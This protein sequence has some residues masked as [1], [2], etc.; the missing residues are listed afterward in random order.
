MPG[1]DKN[2]RPEDNTQGFQVN[3]QNI[4]RA[5]QPKKFKG[6][7]AT[8]RELLN[9]DGTIVIENVYEL[10]E[11][12]NETGKK[13]KKAKV[14]I[15]RKDIIILAAL[16]KSVQGDMRAVE[17]V[18][19]RIEGKALQPFRLESEGPEINLEQL[20]VKE[21]QQWYKLLDKALV[22]NDI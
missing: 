2:I 20:T 15:P 6:L 4:N 14:K 22:K 18:F 10:D 12:N 16:K 11:N 21:R 5:G 13:F 8:L 3:P 1:G 19:D 17:F 7:T 9:T